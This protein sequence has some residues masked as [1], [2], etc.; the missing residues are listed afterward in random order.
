MFTKNISTLPAK[1]VFDSQRDRIVVVMIVDSTL[2]ANGKIDI[3][4]PTSNKNVR[5]NWSGDK[6]L[7]ASFYHSLRY[8]ND[9]L[10]V[11]AA[12]VKWNFFDK[13]KSQLIFSMKKV[14][15]VYYNG[16]LMKKF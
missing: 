8:Y 5:M 10:H 15:K 12:L 3:R 9:T 2:K 6:E 11:D 13:S 4:R 7:I 16:R 1:S 14:A